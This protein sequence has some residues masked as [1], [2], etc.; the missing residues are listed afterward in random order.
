MSAFTKGITNFQE[1]GSL[2]GQSYKLWKDCAIETL[3]NDYNR[4]YVFKDNFLTLPTGKYTATQATAG[5]FALGDDEGGVALADCNSTTVT[6]GINVQLNSTVGA[7][8]RTQAS[9]KLWFEARLKASDIAT[10]PEFFCGLSSIDT[11][12]IGTS[13]NTSANHIGFESVSDDG[14]L[15]F[16]AEVAGVRTSGTATIHTLVEDTYVRLGFK[17]VDRARIE[18]YVN[19][20]KVDTLTAGFPLVGMV[21]SLVCQ[22][23]GATDSIVHLDWWDCAVEKTAS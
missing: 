14:V 15:L 13:A 19:G 2:V 21:P 10:G 22:S 8:F 18:V 6:Q 23:D 3:A 12:I 5:T 4:G 9:G 7:A 16:H 20:A 17:V 1:E 11:T